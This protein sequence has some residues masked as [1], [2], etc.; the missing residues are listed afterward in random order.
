MKNSKKAFSLVE[1]LVALIIV[2]LI[3]AALAPVITKKL[4][5]SGVT[6]TGGGSNA[7]EIVTMM[8]ANMFGDANC[9]QCS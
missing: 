5:S 1:I 9:V 8:C 3:T 7:Q 6:I 4:S 2:S